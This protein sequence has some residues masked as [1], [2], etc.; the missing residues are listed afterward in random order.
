MLQDRHVK[1]LE[2]R[3]FDPELL[4]RLGVYSSD[5]LGQDCIAIPYFCNGDDIANVKYRTIAGEKR[6]LQESGREPRFYN[7][8]AI[9]DPTLQSTPLIITEGELDAW[10][11]MQAGFAR[12]V[13]VPNGAPST[14][15]PADGARYRFLDNAPAALWTGEI[16][17]AT[18]ADN[19]G[20]V[21]MNDL[22]VRLKRA[23]CRW[24]RYPRGCKDLADA[25]KAHGVR[26]VTATI[27]RAAWMQLDGLYRMSEM[28]PLPEIKALDSGFPNLGEH[29]RL[30]PGDMTVITGIPSHGKTTFVNDLACRMA[31]RHKWPVAFASFEQRPQRD[32]RRYLRTWYNGKFVV[33]QTPEEISK[34]DAWIDDMLYF[35]SPADNENPSL[36]WVIDKLESAVIRYGAKLCVIDP[37][38]EI[39]HDKRGMPT[40]D[41]TSWALRELRALARNYQMHL[42]LVAHPAKM[43][44]QDDGKYPIPTLYDIADSAAW[45]N[46]PD[47]GIVVYRKS[48]EINTTIRIQKVRFHDEIGRPG[49][50]KVRYEPT[51]A[52][53]VAAE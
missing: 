14:P 39:E 49:D 45:Y 15:T 40:A 18:D 41:Y 36:E 42:I 51:R 25:L 7:E 23:R 53:F 9:S 37:W 29:Y 27:A 11:A 30:R 47:V 34:A 20:V 35:V 22:A 6:F 1:I 3:G 52:T 31:M 28:P 5:E 33:H 46:R 13:S 10:A 8:A 24:V 19:P 4:A 32:H 44:R 12:V 43:K 2:T 21:L 26:G 16:I 38:N 48:N 50:I 17:L